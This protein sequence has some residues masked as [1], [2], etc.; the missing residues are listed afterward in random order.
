MHPSFVKHGDTQI[1]LTIRPTRSSLDLS[2]ASLQSTSEY[3]PN[4]TTLFPSHFFESLD[5]IPF[6][7]LQNHL[8]HIYTNSEPA[9]ITFLLLY[10][11]LSLT[12]YVIRRQVSR[13]RRYNMIS[14]TEHWRSFPSF[15]YPTNQLLVFLKYIMRHRALCWRPTDLVR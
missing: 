7:N 1:T 9:D 3:P 12:L 13:I 11:M 8:L 10:I 4:E 2:S 5:H 15:G 14:E 6:Q